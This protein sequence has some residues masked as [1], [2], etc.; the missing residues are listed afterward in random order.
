MDANLIRFEVLERTFN[1]PHYA[2]LGYFPDES[3]EQ[4][5][6]RFYCPFARDGNGWSRDIE[7]MNAAAARA[8]LE[9]FEGW[10]SE[11]RAEALRLT[12]LRWRALYKKASLSKEREE[13]VE[14]MRQDEAAALKMQE[15]ERAAAERVIVKNMEA[16]AKRESKA[17]AKRKE[18]DE[19]AAEE[20]KRKDEMFKEELIKEEQ[21]KREAKKKAKK[22]AEEQAALRAREEDEALDKA[23]KEV[24]M[25]EAAKQEAANKKAKILADIVLEKTK[26]AMEIAELK[27][28]AEKDL[29]AMVNQLKF[30][31]QM[32]NVPN[33]PVNLAMYSFLFCCLMRQT[34]M[35]DMLLYFGA[36]VQ[37]AD[38]PTYS[39]FSVLFKDHQQ[40]STA[41]RVASAVP[42]LYLNSSQMTVA[43][44]LIVQTV[45][46]IVGIV[47]DLRRL[48]KSGN[49]EEDYSPEFHSHFQV[50]FSICDQRQFSMSILEGIDSLGPLPELIGLYK[51]VQ[52]FENFCAGS[53][54][55]VFRQC[56]PLP[57][58][59]MPQATL[60][61]KSPQQTYDFFLNI[62][63]SPTL[64]K[65]MA[66]TQKLHDDLA[67]SGKHSKDAEMW[68]EFMQKITESDGPNIF[69][70]TRLVWQT[71]FTTISKWYVSP[72]TLESI[73]STPVFEELLP[74]WFGADPSKKLQ[75]SEREDFATEA[76]EDIIYACGLS[77]G[78]TQSQ[79]QILAFLLSHGT[80]SAISDWISSRS[81][82]PSLVLPFTTTIQKVSFSLRVPFFCTLSHAPPS[83]PMQRWNAVCS[84]HTNTLPIFQLNAR[85]LVLAKKLNLS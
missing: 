17:E 52:V 19:R 18:Q 4:W 71:N 76:L 8:L 1:T 10:S 80:G 67:K 78:Q 37:K 75:F 69:D 12:A 63:M 47:F 44:Q 79:Q 20:K 62:G 83:L 27:R 22:A 31:P 77:M 85:L 26:N 73:N 15:E 6:A 64:S 57:S 50:L 24:E 74:S 23:L 58:L 49:C 5:A 30:F 65:D 56:F 68:F 14:F 82:L 54:F 39:N 84:I 48:I 16:K 51:S 53:D 35:M 42:P 2:P 66:A 34:L 43:A 81:P 11:K 61:G 29:D 72:P 3:Y 55:I 40:L 38:L 70:A 59:G 32:E 36:W 25:A 9:G 21:C 28:N 46:N 33:I 41:V 7:G 45:R 60:P 13:L